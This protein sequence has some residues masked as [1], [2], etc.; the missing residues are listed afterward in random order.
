VR[1]LTVPSKILLAARFTDAN[2]D[3]FLELSLTGIELD[4][5]RVTRP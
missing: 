5:V 4:N 2:N 1:F 3:Y